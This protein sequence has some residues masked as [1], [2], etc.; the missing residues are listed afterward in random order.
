MEQGKGRQTQH[1][2]LPTIPPRMQT[3]G[4][5]VRSKGLIYHK[6]QFQQHPEDSRRKS[7][8]EL[9]NKEQLPDSHLEL[10][11]PGLCFFK[12]KLSTFV[13]T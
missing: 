12:G 4:H 13:S 8:T 2:V 6:K 11:L 10:R 1:S 9:M 7:P 5:P 3:A